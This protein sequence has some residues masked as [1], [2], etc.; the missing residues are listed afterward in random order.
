MKLGRPGDRERYENPLEKA[1]SDE[2]EDD[3]EE[4]EEEEDYSDEA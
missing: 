3:G 4:Y 2:E 1:D